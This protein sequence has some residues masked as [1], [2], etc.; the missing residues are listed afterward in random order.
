MSA[1]L[2]AAKR[3]G[4]MLSLLDL[5]EDPVEMFL[6]LIRALPL[7]HEFS[8]NLLRSQLDDYGIPDKSRAGL[9]AKAC[10]LGLI[11]PM[12]LA[13][14]S[15]EVAVTEPSTGKSAHAAHVRVYR[16]VASP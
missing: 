8:V 13:A 5:L 9:F 3:E 14:G 1:D 16:R 6:D 10:S 2:V 7:G 11:V 12:T 4:Q 15:R